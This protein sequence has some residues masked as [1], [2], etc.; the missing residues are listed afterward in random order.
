V[1]AATGARTRSV[2]ASSDEGLLS[3]TVPPCEGGRGRS[4]RQQGA[5]LLSAVHTPGPPSG[6]TVG[7][8]G[9][10]ADGGCT[11]GGSGGACAAARV[12][13]PGV[14]RARRCTEGGHC[15]HGQRPLRR[16]VC[17]S[18]PEPRRGII[19]ERIDTLMLSHAA[20]TH[21]LTLVYF[22]EK[23]EIYLSL[24]VSTKNQHIQQKAFT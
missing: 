12:Y 18:D 4:E 20:Y 21:W 1:N 7:P 13:T 5:A 24:I 19:F 16:G 11:R 2:D 15:R 10:G 8:V 17:R 9:K 22:S 6:S 23:P 14:T 3:T